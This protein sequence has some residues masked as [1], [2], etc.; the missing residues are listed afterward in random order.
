MYI[1]IYISIVKHLSMMFCIFQ[2]TSFALFVKFILK[3]LI[4][5]HA[6]VSEIIL[7]ISVSDSSLLGIEMQLISYIYPVLSMY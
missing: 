2:C 7:L 1:Y 3:Y 4:L 5:L 6:T